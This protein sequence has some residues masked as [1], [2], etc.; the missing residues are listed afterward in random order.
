MM[1]SKNMVT[2][3]RK[4]K[5]SHSVGKIEKK[6][7]S[8]ECEINFLRKRGLHSNQFIYPENGDISVVDNDDIVKK[9]P[10]PAM[11][12]GTLRTA[13]ILTFIFDFSSFENVI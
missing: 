9:L 10:K 2:V 8:S 5:I 11:L 1:V 6:T 4:E 13:R 3:S 7:P 12:A